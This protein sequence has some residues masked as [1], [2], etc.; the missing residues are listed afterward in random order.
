MAIDTRVELI[1]ALHEAAEIEHGLMI[2]YLFPAFSLKKRADEGLRPAQLALAREWGATILGVAVE[3]MGHLGTVCN[4]LAAIGEGPRFERPNLPQTVGYYPF[5]FDLV[6]F[7]DEALY[8]MLVFELPRGEP[9]PAPPFADEIAA[10]SLALAAPEPLTYD[11]VGE[12]YEKI[13]DGFG[14]IAESEL[15]IG[16]P[17]AQVADTWSVR[18]DLRPVTSQASAF[19]A[20]DDIILDGEGAPADRMTSHYGR[21]LGIRNAYA[22]A[23]RFAA[24]RPVVTNPQTRKKRGTGPGT[25]LTFELATNVAELFNEVYAAALL[26]LQ[27]FFAF[28]GETQQQREALK[29]AAGQLMSTAVRPVSEVLTELPAFDPADERRAGAPFELYDAVSVSP[30]LSARWT[31]LLERLQAVSDEALALGA[32]VPRL[33]AVGETVKFLRRR[34]TEV[35]P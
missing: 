25:L 23:G 34:M 12:L 20:I 26:I 29:A 13:R 24:A 32:E 27:Q 7:G 30:F 22:R 28:A 14:A 31:I 33:A 18:L 1:A 17:D 8:R 16:P 5:P 4:L 3:E 6:P 10:D 11:Y 35:A 21:F 15:F 19:D 2:Q 9:L